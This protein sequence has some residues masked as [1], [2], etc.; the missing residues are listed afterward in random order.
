MAEQ[1]LYA[2]LAPSPQTLGP[3]KAACHTWADHLWAEVSVICEEKESVELERLK[4][5]F[6]EGTSPSS[7]IGEAGVEEWEEN[8]IKSLE[9]LGSIGV[10]EG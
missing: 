1:A 8:V 4:G 2:A 7:G 3:L 10:D 9:V 5:S 6:W